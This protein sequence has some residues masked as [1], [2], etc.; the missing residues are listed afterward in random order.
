MFTPDDRTRA[1]TAFLI[2][3]ENLATPAK[4]GVYTHYLPL[5]RVSPYR[6][7]QTGWL[8]KKFSSFCFGRRAA[9]LSPA[10]PHPHS[11]SICPPFQVLALRVEHLSYSYV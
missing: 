9:G 8:A 6:F 1:Q 7:T 5:G 3:A 11:Y 2:M 4:E 10:G